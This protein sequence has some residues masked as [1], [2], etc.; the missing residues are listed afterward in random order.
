MIVNILHQLSK[1]VTS[2][3]LLLL[4]N[5]IISNSSQKMRKL[6]NIKKILKKASGKVCLD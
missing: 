4:L 3:Y 6:W 5:G 2:V 1:R